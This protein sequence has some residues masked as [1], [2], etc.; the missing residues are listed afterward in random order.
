MG[1]LLLGTGNSTTDPR[2]LRRH[3]FQAAAPAALHRMPP[4]KKDHRD[5]RTEQPANDIGKPAK[6][7][8]LT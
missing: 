2:A 8:Y 7:D 3:C 1:E 6:L 5:P 4:H